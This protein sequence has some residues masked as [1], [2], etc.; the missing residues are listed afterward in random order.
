[1]YINVKCI[2]EHLKTTCLGNTLIHLDSV[3]S[4]NSY[5]KNLPDSKSGTVVIADMQ[6]GG[7]GRR[8]R[9]FWSPTG[10]IYLS[11][12]YIPTEPIDVGKITSCVALSVCKSIEKLVELEP[13]IKWV[14]DVFINNKK[15]CGILCE[16]ITNSKTSQIEGIVI[17]IGFNVCDS[18]IPSELEA[19]VTNLNYES[20]RENSHNVIIAEILNN[21]ESELKNINAGGLIQELTKRSLV[22]GR[23]IFV[24]NINESYEAEAIG[25]DSSCGLIVKRGEDVFSLSTGEVSIVCN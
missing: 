19:I 6:T 25:L 14:N 18:S 15:I 13:K 24:N 17:G 22:I 12:M 4:T 3:D 2:K 8:G 23:K 10:G 5:L 7:R 20:G 16:A 1:M 9:S 11:V 21:L